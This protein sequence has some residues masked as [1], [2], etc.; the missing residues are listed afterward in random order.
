MYNDIVT[1]DVAIL[2]KEIGFNEPCWFV[3]TDIN[4]ENPDAKPIKWGMKSEDTFENSFN[5]HTASAP[6]WSQVFRW[7]RKEYSTDSYIKKESENTYFY[8]IWNGVVWITNATN[9][10]EDSEKNCVLELIHMLKQGKISN[11]NINLD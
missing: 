4:I 2:L 1:F 6:M 11:Q 8:H 3:Y 5:K 7:F 9:S 10:Y